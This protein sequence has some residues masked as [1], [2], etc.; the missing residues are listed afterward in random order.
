MENENLKMRWKAKTFPSPT[1]ILE[2]SALLAFSLRRT[3]GFVF[4]LQNTINSAYVYFVHKIM[5]SC[6]T[7][8]GLFITNAVVNNI[9][10]SFLK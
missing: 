9:N 8:A 4:F 7:S 3:T 2:A 5:Q 10:A 6:A 1:D